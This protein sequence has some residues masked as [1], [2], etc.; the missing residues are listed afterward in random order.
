MKKIRTSY[1]YKN[2]FK[3]PIYYV[4]YSDL[5]NNVSNWKKSEHSH[6]FS[7]IVFVKKG[8]GQVVINGNRSVLSDSRLSG[9]IIGLT[10]STKADEIYLALA[11]SMVF[12]TRAIVENYRKNGIDVDKIV[13]AGGIAEKSDFVTQLFSDILNMPVCKAGSSQ[14]G[15]LGSA[16]YASVAAGADNG[17]YD[18]L[19]KAALCMGSLKDKV[20]TP[21]PIRLKAYDK[22]YAVYSELYEKF[23]REGKIMHTL[24]EIAKES[25]DENNRCD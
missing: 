12:G 4:I 8:R 13:L 18:D 15:A 20:F 6:P 24:K 17:G 23:G 21:D 16:I 7:E 2:S 3:Q 10:L 9:A 11:E 19:R 25:T 22:L 5:V 1:S 14:A